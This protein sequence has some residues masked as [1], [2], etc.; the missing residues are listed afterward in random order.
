MGPSERG[1]FMWV[2]LQPG[3]KNGHGFCAFQVKVFLLECFTVN[4]N[5]LFQMEFYEKRTCFRGKWLRDKNLV[6]FDT[7]RVKKKK[8]KKKDEKDQINGFIGMSFI[9]QITCQKKKKTTDR[10]GEESKSK[11]KVSYFAC[12]RHTKESKFRFPL[13]HAED[14]HHI[15]NAEVTNKRWLL[16]IFIHR[17]FFLLLLPLDLDFKLFQRVKTKLQNVCSILLSLFY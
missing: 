1:S 4:S 6:I 7:Y 16:Q 14:R 3:L 8:K 12:E 2:R 11:V 10:S 9:E 5:E 17:I 15:H 13:F